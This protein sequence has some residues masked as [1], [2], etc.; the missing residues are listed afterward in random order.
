MRLSTISEWAFNFVVLVFATGAIAQP[1]VIPS[2]S[3]ESTLMTGDHVL[4]DKLAYAPSGALGR[5]LLPYE[6]VKHGDIV[7]FRYPVDTRQNF[8][9]RVI[10]LPGDRIHIRNRVVY[11][12]GQALH[13]NYVQA[14]FPPDEYRDNFPLGEPH[15]GELFTQGAS[16]LSCCVENGEL[17]VPEGNYFA[18]GDNRDNS[19]DSRY[20]GFVPAAN[21]V[22]KPVLV[23][24]SYD[25]PENELVDA[26]NARHIF[27]LAAHFFTK[28]RWNRTMRPVRTAG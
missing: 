10:G 26:V 28:T 14:I 9:K 11:R 5:R 21:I 18:M 6:P 13:E 2:A 27:D 8:V 20:W 4:V 12:N 15:P 23:W 17:V 1:F 7:V 25:A 24:W 16:M 3:M 22:G 19:S